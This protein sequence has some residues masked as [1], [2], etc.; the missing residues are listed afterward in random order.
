[1]FT[2]QPI[3]E[4]NIKTW[5]GIVRGPR[6]RRWSRWRRIRRARWRIGGEILVVWWVSNHHRHHIFEQALWAYSFWATVH[7]CAVGRACGRVFRASLVIVF[8]YRDGLLRLGLGVRDIIALELLGWWVDVLLGWWV[9][10]KIRVRKVE[11]EAL[12]GDDESVRVVARALDL[13]LGTASRVCASVVAPVFHHSNNNTWMIIE[14]I[15][16]QLQHPLGL[17]LSKRIG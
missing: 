12:V 10:E 7:E 16:V 9:E 4:A 3:I 11:V 2:W 13:L 14:N 17:C 5:S 1:M 6:E 15:R 8:L